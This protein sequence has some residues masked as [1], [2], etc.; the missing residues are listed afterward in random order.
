MDCALA[1]DAT[2]D[3]VAALRTFPPQLVCHDGRMLHAVI[4]A[5][6][7]GTRLWPLSRATNPK[8]L[9]LLTGTEETLLQATATRLEAVSPLSDTLVVTGAA[10]AAEVARQLPGLP[11]AN[12]LVEPC[13]RDSCA[14]IGLAAP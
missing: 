1:R 3:A 6:G 7:S 14:A 12:I 5:G 8:F 10:H 9:H 11:A 4:P 13:A 2:P